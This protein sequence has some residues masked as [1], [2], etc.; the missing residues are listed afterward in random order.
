MFL[1]CP[2]QLLSSSSLHPVFHPSFHPYN[3]FQHLHASVR[4]LSLSAVLVF[5]VARLEVGTNAAAEASYDRAR[6]LAI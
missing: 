5:T 1:H 2:S 3:I 6:S 4:S